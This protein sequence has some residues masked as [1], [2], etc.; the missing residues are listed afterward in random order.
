MFLTLLLMEK[1][2]CRIV[3]PGY[4]QLK[5]EESTPLFATAIYSTANSNAY[6]QSSMVETR[7]SKLETP[8]IA[9]VHMAMVKKAL[10]ILSI[11]FSHSS[12]PVTT[13]LPFFV[14]GSMCKMWKIA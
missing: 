7:N 1:S 14:L 9:V 11:D 6:K 3:E 4:A 2:C 10:N 13:S 5:R 8:G 12:R